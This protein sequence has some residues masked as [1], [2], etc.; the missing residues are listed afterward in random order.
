MCRNSL[1]ASSRRIEPDPECG[2]PILTG[3][4][5]L[6]AAGVG[7]AVEHLGVDPLGIKKPT[8]WSTAA[9]TAGS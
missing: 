7:D 4:Q 5:E 8:H 6:P 3:Q 9:V 1:R 2:R